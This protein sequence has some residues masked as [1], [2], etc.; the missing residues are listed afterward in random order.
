[1]F[2]NIWV[3]YFVLYIFAFGSGKKMSYE[4]E[5]IL[6]WLETASTTHVKSKK[7]E[8]QC[9]SS[10][11]PRLSKT[12]NELYKNG[13]FSSSYASSLAPHQIRNQRKVSHF[14]TNYQRQLHI[15]RRLYMMSVWEKETNLTS[16][17][18]KKNSEESL[19]FSTW[20]LKMQKI[21]RTF[22]M[23]GLNCAQTRML[24][25]MRKTSTPKEIRL[26][27]E[28]AALSN[29][30]EE[31]YSKAKVCNISQKYKDCYN[32]E[33]GL[34]NLMAKS[35]NYKTLLSAWKK[36]RDAIG[37]HI[38]HAWIRLF[39]INNLGAKENGFND[40]GAYWRSVYGVKNFTS[41]IDSLWLKIRPLY[42]ELHAFVRHRLHLKYGD[43]VNLT[44]PIPAHLLGN[45]WAMQWNNIYDMCK[46]FKDVD[47]FKVNTGMKM[48]NYTV[49]TM[50][51][52]ADHFYQSIGLP[53]MP[54]SFWRHSMFIRPEN[55]SAVCYA[56]AFN[57]EDRDVRVKMCAELNEEYL[58]VVHHE[59]GHC[60]YYLAY[61]LHQP[62]LFQSG[63]NPGFHE[64]IGDTA[65]LSVLN[66]THLRKLGIIK[67]SK[68]KV[69][70]KK[71]HINFL[72]KKA[73]GKL[74]FYPYP[75]ALESWR[76]KVFAGS[77]PTNQLNAGYWRERLRY[78]GIAPPI[79]RS[80]NDFDPGAKFHVTN[81]VPY[82]RYFISHVLQF[83]FYESM[84]KRSLHK[85]PLHNCDF[86]GSKMAGQPFAEM[87]RLGSS[88]S[89]KYAL[90][91]MTGSCGIEVQPIIE[92]FNPLVKWLQK[93]NRRL[94][95]KIGW[96]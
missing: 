46:P 54:K 80:E 52:L 56:S 23:N 26:R 21:A 45:M 79:E 4:E 58:Y 76:W 59:M 3:L 47:E 81:N 78:Q 27:N 11:E 20:Q 36:W 71:Q 89:W 93:E 25:S 96:D 1:M 31:I 30:I 9:S 50:F 33:P 74:A 57:L 61:N 86:A 67:R 69:N 66:P 40:L 84:C 53:A 48:R 91:E 32:F 64:A 70:K 37:P 17:N 2:G 44:G 51:T 73:L 14:L 8:A 75:L 12:S 85:G 77:L 13:L 95:S 39:Q 34:I 49:D 41:T 38:R 29:K 55:R 60:Q 19:K 6:Y 83:Q 72:M 87:L 35:R 63:A 62:E 15:H 92:Y 10:H 90:K 22:S 88:K 24:K 18:I 82:I 42:L 5:D 43:K 7:C 94:R 68:S 28:S 65:A 16:H